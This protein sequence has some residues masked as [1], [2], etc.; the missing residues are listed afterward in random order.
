MECLVRQKFSYPSLK[1]QLLQTSNVKLIE[2]NEW[3]DRFWGM[4]RGQNE[5]HLGKI[6][7]KIRDEYNGG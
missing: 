6:L 2:G 3:K 5:N 7:M 4:Y 1:L